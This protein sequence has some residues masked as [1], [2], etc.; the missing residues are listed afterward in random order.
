[1]AGANLS[2]TWI[3]AKAAL[4][5]ADGKRYVVEFH[6]PP[7]TR[8]YALDVKGSVQPTSDENALVHFNRDRNPQAEEPMEFEARAGWTWW[9]KTDG[10]GSRVV[11][12]E[13]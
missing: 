13:I 4:S 5:M 12:A 7:A 9:L 2:S 8:I 6:G 10:G 3:E 11:S 1:M